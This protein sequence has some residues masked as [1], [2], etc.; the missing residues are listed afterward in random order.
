MLSKARFTGR[1]YI[2]LR[3]IKGFLEFRALVVGIGRL[4][5]CE[6]GKCFQ[7]LQSFSKAWPI[8]RRSI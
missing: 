4:E 3:E 8:D 1:V 5:V 7:A 6:V 2:G